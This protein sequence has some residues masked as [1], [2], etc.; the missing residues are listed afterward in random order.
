ML[1]AAAGY[2]QPI[3]SYLRHSDSADYNASDLIPSVT[4][5]LGYRTAPPTAS[6]S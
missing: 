5:Y 1:F 6:R 2:L 4:Y 3:D